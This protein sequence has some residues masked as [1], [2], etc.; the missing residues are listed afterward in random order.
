MEG[1]T[2]T[3]GAM[4]TVEQVWPSLAPL[5][6]VPHGEREYNQLVQMLDTLIDAVGEDE[7]HPLA[8]LMEIVSVLIEKYED[9]NVPE[10][11]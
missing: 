5:L 4:E 9:E 11:S 2:M 10:L 7:A 1:M 6:F 8:S 3:T